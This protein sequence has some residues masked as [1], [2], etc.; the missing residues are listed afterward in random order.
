MHHFPMKI[1]YFS[2]FPLSSWKSYC[3]AWASFPSLK[4]ICGN[5]GSKSLTIPKSISF[6]LHISKKIHILSW[7]NAGENGE[8]EADNLMHFCFAL[9][10]TIRNGTDIF[11]SIF[12]FGFLW[13]VDK[14]LKLEDV[15]TD[16]ET[17]NGRFPHFVFTIF[18]CLWMEMCEHW[19]KNCFLPKRDDLPQFF[20]C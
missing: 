16:E 19:I 7:K 17:C 1:F 18:F 13:Q 4:L 8:D 20:C 12:Q 3:T 2:I 9:E 10:C 6:G 14:Y 15:D 5:F 11:S